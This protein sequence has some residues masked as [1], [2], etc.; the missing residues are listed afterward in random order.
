MAPL[1]LRA[2]LPAL[3]LP[4]PGESGPGPAPLHS[5][6]PH[7][8]VFTRHREREPAPRFVGAATGGAARP[9]DRGRRRAAG[10]CGA[11]VN[12]PL[13]GGSEGTGGA[14]AAGRFGFAN[15]FL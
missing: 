1:R 2:L 10:P 12:G 6:P 11:A 14:P 15:D 7:V 4:L 3:L 13:A 8:V 5:A 9:A